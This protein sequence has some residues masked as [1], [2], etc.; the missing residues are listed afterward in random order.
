MLSGLAKFEGR[1]SLRTWV[2]TNL[3]NRAR[4]CG[5]REARIVPRPSLG[6]Q[7]ERASDDRFSGHGGAA[8]RTWSSIGVI[9]RCDTVPERVTLL[10]EVLLALDRTLSAPP[11]RQRRMRTMRDVFG[12]PAEQV[13]AALGVS[14]A[15]QR[16]LLHRA[17]GRPAAVPRRVSRRMTGTRIRLRWAGDKERK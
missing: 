15:Y 17:P 5:A 11:P 1:S 2:F 14:P 12:T 7:D 6:S 9:S 10:R 13:C 16:V 4:S 3:V 8:P